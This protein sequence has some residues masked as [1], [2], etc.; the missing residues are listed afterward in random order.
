MAERDAI[1]V[2]ARNRKARH[3]FELLE[4]FEAGLVLEGAEVKSLRS[5]RASFADSF[6]RVHRGEVWLHNL[7]IPRYENSSLDDLDPVRKRKLLLNRREI[8]SIAS[9]TRERGLTLVPLDVHFKRGYAKVTVALARGKKHRDRRE[10]LKRKTMER[11]AERA[12]RD[13]RRDR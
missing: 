5:G 4:Q 10:D 9:Q 2:V 1:R 7:H 8:E 6:G 3:E 12:E 13:A 11:E